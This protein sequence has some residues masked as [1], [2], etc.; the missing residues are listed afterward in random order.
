MP[1]EKLLESGEVLTE[2]ETFR[3]TITLHGDLKSFIE[4]RAKAVKYRDLRGQPNKS[5]YMRDLVAAEMIRFVGGSG[6]GGAPRLNGGKRN[7]KAV[8]GAR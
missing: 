4:T 7:G 1:Q 3:M 5:A 8:R 2:P 6:N